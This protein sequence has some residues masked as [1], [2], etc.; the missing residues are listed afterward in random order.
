MRL[1]V[2]FSRTIQN[3]LVQHGDENVA[4]RFFGQVTA[5]MKLN[6]QNVFASPD[7]CLWYDHISFISRMS[8]KTAR[9]YTIRT[10]PSRTDSVHLISHLIQN[11]NTYKLP[12]FI[13]M[14]SRGSETVHITSI[15]WWRHSHISLGNL[16]LYIWSHLCCFTQLMTFSSLFMLIV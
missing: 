3:H 5:Q 11:E 13:S 15:A 14:K 8:S 12:C 2:Y 4:W 9:T 10:M 6:F 16:Y 1:T 7:I